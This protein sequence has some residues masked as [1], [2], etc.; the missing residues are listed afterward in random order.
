MG[1][2]DSDFPWVILG[3]LAICLVIAW[4]LTIRFVVDAA[5]PQLVAGLGL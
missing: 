3:V 1:P 2:T 5:G 4:G